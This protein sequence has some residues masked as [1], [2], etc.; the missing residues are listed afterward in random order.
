MDE[1]EKLI[2]EYFQRKLDDPKGTVSLHDQAT[3]LAAG[4]LDPR[5]RRAL[6][7]VMAFEGEPSL[8]TAE[9]DLI[10]EFI[11]SALED[12]VP[13]ARHSMAVAHLKRY[14]EVK[15][16][17][18]VAAR[19][20][21][22]AQIIGERLDVILEDGVIE[23]TEDLEQAELQRMFDLS[24]DE[25]LALGRGAIVRAFAGLSEGTPP[26]TGSPRS[27]GLKLSLLEPLYK[28]ATAHDK[29]SGET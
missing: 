16:G 24:Y 26:Y 11:Q 2:R 29:A 20:N 18:F 12:A 22:I 10:I 5:G 8:R 14:F 4:I 19:A 17:E 23:R 25:Y 3:H 15:E 28:L 7:S 9:L 1:S 13:I 21:V 27:R 6:P